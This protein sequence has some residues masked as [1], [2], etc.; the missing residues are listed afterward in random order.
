M[1]LAIYLLTCLILLAF[2]GI[3]LTPLFIIIRR[4]KKL[5]ISFSNKIIQ[6]LEQELKIAQ[7]LNNLRL[8][9]MVWCLLLVHEGRSFASIAK[10]LNISVRT[11]YNWLKTFIIRQFSWLCGHHYQGRGRKPKL[12]KQQ[13]A[14]LYEIIEKGPL[15]YGFDCGIWNS[16]MIVIVIE[17]KFGVTYNPRYVSYL[18]KKIGLSYQKA[19]FASD[20]LDDEEH[21]KKREKWENKTWPEIL[22]KAKSMKAV[23]LFGDEVSFAQWGSLA[24]TWAPIG[25]QPIVKTCGKRKGLKMFGVIEFKNGGFLYM[26]CDG[27]F[28]GDSY[29]EFL[30]QV[31]NKYA[32]PVILIEDGAP[33]HKGD[34]VNTFKE[35]MQSQGRLFVY[36]LPSY[37]P[38]KNPIEKLWKKT[39]KDATHCKYF[40][41]FD[42]LRSAVVKAFRKYLW[43][44]TH[45][46]SCMKKLR[47]Q[48][49]IA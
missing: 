30:E 49:G 17:N 13:K 12:N 33:Y 37:S 3:I 48:A 21:Q 14:Q 15:A 28:N 4:N 19:K 47:T 46:I 31:L 43:D 5:N 42:D 34:V 41:T 1:Y 8:Y 45:V 40:P 27:K 24:R 9:K 18:L 39:K 11:V 16:A 38:D 6:R 22:D 7:K 23:I 29:V 32:C 44:A 10:L 26:E 2:I 36:R 35:Q 25:K 20:K